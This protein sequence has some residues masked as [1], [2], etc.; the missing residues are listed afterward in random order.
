[1]EDKLKF[2]TAYAWHNDMQFDELFEITELAG[3]VTVFHRETDIVFDGRVDSWADHT[4]LCL[5]LVHMFAFPDFLNGPVRVIAGSREH[6][7]V[8]GSF[9][10][11]DLDLFRDL[12]RREGR[13]VSDTIC[14]K[15]LIPGQWAQV[16][17][18]YHLHYAMVPIALVIDPPACASAG[19]SQE[20]DDNDD[21]VPV[22]RNSLIKVNSVE[23]VTSSLQW[24]EKPV[25]EGLPPSVVLVIVD[26]KSDLIP[27]DFLYLIGQWVPPSCVVKWS[28][29]MIALQDSL[30]RE[31]EQ[32]ETKSSFDPFDVLVRWYDKWGNGASVSGVSYPQ[33]REKWRLSRPYAIRE[34]IG[35]WAFKSPKDGVKSNQKVLVLM[36]FWNNNARTVCSLA[37]LY[38]ELVATGRHPQG[39]RQG[40]GALID[41]FCLLQCATLH[42]HQVKAMSQISENVP[43]SG[44]RHDGRC[45]GLLFD[46]SWTQHFVPLVRRI[47]EFHVNGPVSS[48]LIRWKK[49]RK[50]HGEEVVIFGSWSSKQVGSF[51]LQSLCLEALS[52]RGIVGPP[53]LFN[54]KFR[55]SF[56]KKLEMQV[57]RRGQYCSRASI[58]VWGCGFTE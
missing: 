50:V 11:A 27:F 44:V 30:G 1:M 46:R 12:I 42:V 6:L 40:N 45:W 16:W 38:R 35:K 49:K 4:D 47:E 14:N 53:F 37:D 43:S 13:Q 54:K 57:R 17:A 28:K 20:G 23:Q 25:P 51:S 15:I 26:S 24:E 58:E 36:E 48:R 8:D 19:E 29:G 3:R 31:T 32:L 22:L 9:K 41:A 34:W 52:R 55:I 21:R 5:R 7:M 56:A 10:K 39:S 2:F 33:S 18:E